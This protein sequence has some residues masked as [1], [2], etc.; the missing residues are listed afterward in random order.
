VVAIHY[1]SIRPN[2]V[3]SLQTPVVN[4]GTA[5]CLAWCDGS[6]RYLAAFKI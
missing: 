3:V 1:R 2:G 4:R 6:A 5:I